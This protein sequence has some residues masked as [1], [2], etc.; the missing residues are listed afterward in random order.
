MERRPSQGPQSTAVRKELQLRTLGLIL[1]LLLRISSAA[2]SPV[3]PA[4]TSREG[5]D[6]MAGAI[7]Q[8]SK[9]IGAQLHQP[10]SAGGHQAGTHPG[11]N[12]GS[13]GGFSVLGMVPSKT[14]L[15]AALL[16]LHLNFRAPRCCL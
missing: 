9:R 7:S 14:H 13:R 3:F 1:D 4:L 15:G 5:R 11:A 8:P 6:T 12:P 16:L 10:S 2:K